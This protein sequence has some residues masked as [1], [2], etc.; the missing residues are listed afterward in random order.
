MMINYIKRWLTWHAAERRQFPDLDSSTT[1]TRSYL[2][3]YIHIN[4]AINDTNQWSF[5]QYNQTA[6]QSA[7]KIPTN[8]TNLLKNVQFASCLFDFISI[9]E[10]DTYFKVNQKQMSPN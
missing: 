5:W 1:S 6:R 10:Q 9:W 3:F 4:Q 7:S 2:N 8:Q